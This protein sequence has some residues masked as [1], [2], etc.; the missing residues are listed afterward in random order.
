M[1]YPLALNTPGPKPAFAGK[2][3]SEAAGK[4]LLSRRK[5]TKA[6]AQDDSPYIGSA[7]AHINP[8]TLPVFDTLAGVLRSNK[9]EHL[10]G[11]GKTKRQQARMDALV[12]EFN[13]RFASKNIHIEALGDGFHGHAFKLQ[14]PEKSY[15]LKI[16][17]A[18]TLLH[19]LANHFDIAHNSVWREIALGHYLTQ[20]PTADMAEFYVGNPKAGWYLCEFLDENTQLEGRPGKTLSEQGFMSPDNF[21]NRINGVRFDYGFLHKINPFKPSVH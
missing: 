16:E 10:L 7:P 3:A 18:G 12:E 1:F 6:L 13:Q 15:L 11:P 2:A 14:T 5:M 4:K 9:V 19:V 20:Q 17:K 8:A 21:R